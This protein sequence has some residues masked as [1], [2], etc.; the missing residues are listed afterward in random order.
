VASGTRDAGR[1]GFRTELRP[2][3]DQRRLGQRLASSWRDKHY[4]KQKLEA[5]SLVYS[6]ALQVIRAFER[7]SH[8]EQ[9][10]ALLC[11]TCHRLGGSLWLSF[12][13]AYG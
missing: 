9:A 11:G 8:S 3:G 12:E 7:R 13:S 5:T 4:T 10:W 2:A 1:G 6:K